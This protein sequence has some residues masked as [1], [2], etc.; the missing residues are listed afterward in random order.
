MT[1]RL[2]LSLVDGVLAL[3]RLVKRSIVLF[4]DVTTCFLSTWIAFYLRLGEFV[5]PLGATIWGAGMVSATVLSAFL[6]IP[7]FMLTGLYQTIFRHSGWPAFLTLAK[8]VLFYGLC[9]LIVILAAV[10]DGIPRTVGFIQPMLLLLFVGS[11]RAFARAW[12]GNRHRAILSNHTISGVLIYGAGKTGRQLA[13]ALISG[14]EMRVLGFLDDDARLHGNKLNNQPV[15]DPAKITDIVQRLRVSCVLLAMPNIDRHRRNQIIDI[16]V[17]SNVGVRTVP[18]MLDMIQGRRNVS[19]LED[20]GL[21]DLLN[22]DP[23]FP[24]VDLMAQNIRDKVILVTGAGGSIGSELCLQLLPMTPKKLLLVDSSEFSL[25]KI[26]QRAQTVFHKDKTEVIPLLGSVQDAQ[27][28]RAIIS[29]WRPDSIYH[30]AAYKHVPLVEHNQGE[31]IK[32]NVFGTYVTAKISLE[33]GVPNFTLIST[34][35]AVRPTN[36]MGASKRLAEIIL[37]AFDER[38]E[39]TK[40]A[41]VRFGNVLG[42][43]GSVVPLFREQIKNGGPVTVTHADVERYFMTTAEASQLVIQASAMARGGEVFVLDMG[44]PVKILDLARRVIQLSGSS[45][46]DEFN[47]K[48]GIEIKFTGLRTGEKLHEELL[49]GDKPS[50]TLHPRIWSAQEDYV[51]WEDLEDRLTKLG[52]A[53]EAGDLDVARK[54]VSELVPAFTPSI[55]IVDWVYSERGSDVVH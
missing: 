12:L 37:Q 52:C 46:K 26:H 45:V 55:D 9:Y 3:P 22:R 23:I 39:T 17:R 34:D 14:V 50:K 1:T 15:Y 4:V 31:G 54:I 6:A 10:F 21:D 18:S 32:N 47:S 30:A 29:T 42:S 41:I 28:M 5:S 49:I 16:L 20:L 33:L 44:E 25:Y 53:A 19:D 7:L 13:N 36:I 2:S 35:K 51:C 38:S 24:D 48:G 40:F 27:R 43:S 11:S 8:S